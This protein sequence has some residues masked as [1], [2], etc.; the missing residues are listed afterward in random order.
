MNNFCVPSIFSYIHDYDIMS[1]WINHRPVI[2]ILS[3]SFFLCLV[4]LCCPVMACG[5]DEKTRCRL[6]T[7]IKSLF[8]G[9]DLSSWSVFVDVSLDIVFYPVVKGWDSSEHWW[10]FVH[11]TATCTEAHH[12]M[13]L[14]KRAGVSWFAD[15]WP[16]WVSLIEEKGRENWWQKNYLKK[17]HNI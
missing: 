17:K 11:D 5:K 10:L 12:T 16:P 9:Q 14:P 6:K 15:E 7:R 13:H 8:S 2:V 1:D 3:P 4:P